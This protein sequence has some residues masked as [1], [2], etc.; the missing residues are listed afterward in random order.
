MQEE[1]HIQITGGSPVN[2]SQEPDHPTT[3]PTFNNDWVTNLIQ[4]DR[5]RESP[6]M[7][8]ESLAS[9]SREASPIPDQE[10]APVEQAPKAPLTR[11]ALAEEVDFISDEVKQAGPSNPADGKTQNSWPAI[12]RR[13]GYKPN[14]WCFE[15]VQALLERERNLERDRS[16]GRQ[17]LSAYSIMPR[18]QTFTAFL[19]ECEWPEAA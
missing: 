5:D 10:A 17:F 18:R 14:S 2:D 11:T 13:Q 4:T 15:N 12:E 8:L 7:E 16:R 6:Q 3:L 19:P 9:T 1:D